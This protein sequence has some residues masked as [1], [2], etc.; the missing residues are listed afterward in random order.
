[1]RGAVA[2]NPYEGEGNS[3]SGLPMAPAGEKARPVQT[4]DSAMWLFLKTSQHIGQRDPGVQEQTGP[5][6][7][8]AEDGNERVLRGERGS[9]KLM[10]LP[11][12]QQFSG[13]GPTTHLRGSAASVY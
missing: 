1:M 9:P 4:K 8:G 7:L 2:L 5:A 6:F 11:A 3:V 13:F 12:E 10:Q